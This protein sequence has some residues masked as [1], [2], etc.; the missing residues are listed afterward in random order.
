MASFDRLLAQ[1][2]AIFVRYND[3]REIGGVGPFFRLLFCS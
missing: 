1:T 3:V 2:G